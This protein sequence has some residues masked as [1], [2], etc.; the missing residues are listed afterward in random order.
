MTSSAVPETVHPAPRPSYLVRL[1]RMRR[2]DWADIL[3]A[4]W[5]LGQA[6]HKLGRLDPRSF[7]PSMPSGSTASQR[8]IAP[9]QLDRISRAIGRAA[10]VVPWRS[11]CLVQAEAGRRWIAAL[12]GTAEIR[13]GA[14]KGPDNRLDAHAWLLCGGVTVT[15]G[16]ISRYVPFA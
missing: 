14:R 12:G 6:R 13:L 5:H 4:A 15:G 10:R 7:R 11:D 8:A 9:Q 3:R 2:Q 16:D 1:L